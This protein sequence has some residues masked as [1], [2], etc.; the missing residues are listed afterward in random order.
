MQGAVS[1][2]SGLE[3]KADRQKRL[4]CFQEIRSRANDDMF[5]DLTIFDVPASLLREFAEKII[6]PSYLGG[7][8]DAIKDLMRKAIL[9]YD[10]SGNAATVITK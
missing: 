4:V 10:L 3:R 8:S 5:V 2:V 6:Q 1:A 9:E 7:V